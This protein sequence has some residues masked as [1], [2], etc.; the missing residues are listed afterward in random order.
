MITRFL[1]VATALSILFSQQS[2][3]E[4]SKGAPI[5]EPLKKEVTQEKKTSKKSILLKHLY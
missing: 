3:K 1:I 5:K 4:V 2:C